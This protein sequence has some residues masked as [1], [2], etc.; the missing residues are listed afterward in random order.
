MSFAGDEATIDLG[1]FSAGETFTLQLKLYCNQTADFKLCDEKD[2][3]RYIRLLYEY[4]GVKIGEGDTLIFF[5]PK[6]VGGKLEIGVN[7]VRTCNYY[8]NATN[9]KCE[10][11]KEGLAG[12]GYGL[13]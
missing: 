8:S 3:W 12:S 6:G 9:D 5:V 11:A 4:S 10:N 7:Y 2:T 13:I 1:Y